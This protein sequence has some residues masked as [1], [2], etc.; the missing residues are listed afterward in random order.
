L[1]TSDEEAMN[2]I[3]KRNPFSGFASQH[4]RLCA[5]INGKPC[6]EDA[7]HHVNTGG[8]CGNTCSKCADKIRKTHRAEVTEEIFIDEVAV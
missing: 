1:K 2:C 4:R 7:T 8:W 5:Y 6:G 3:L